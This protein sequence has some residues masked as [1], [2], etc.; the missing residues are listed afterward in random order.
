MVN[1]ALEKMILFEDIDVQRFEFE[2]PDKKDTRIKYLNET[3]L[4]DQKHFLDHET[5]AQLEIKS[6]EG[7]ADWL[8]L[9]YKEY[10]IKIE[11]VTDQSSESFQFVKGFGGIGGFLRFK[12]D[13]D[14]YLGDAAGQDDDFDAEE[15][16]I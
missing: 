8:L 12:I 5:G 14:E 4:K 3:Q 16:F 1:G 11:L 13:L 10:G 2:M 6:Q 9:H 15:D 7:L